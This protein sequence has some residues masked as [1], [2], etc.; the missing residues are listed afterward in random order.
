VR[1]HPFDLPGANALI[2]LGGDRLEKPRI[3]ETIDAGLVMFPP[4]IGPQNI[5]RMRNSTSSSFAGAK[6]HPSERRLAPLSRGL[7]SKEE[8]AASADLLRKLKRGSANG[9]MP[10]LSTAE[11]QS[12]QRSASC[13]VEPGGYTTEQF[14]PASQFDK[15]GS[16]RK[17]ASFAFD[18]STTTKR[19]ELPDTTPGPGDYEIDRGFDGRGVQKLSQS[20]STPCVHMQGK[21]PWTQSVGLPDDI[22]APTA[23]FPQE[24]SRAKKS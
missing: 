8:G 1:E 19:W 20:A 3:P 17:S 18:G 23:Y 16:L 2:S 6:G 9:R 11:L 12:L 4:S 14:M 5:T 21:K 24:D 22:P 10:Q 13:S 15:A 7:L